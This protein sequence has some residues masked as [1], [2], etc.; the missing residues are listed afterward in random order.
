MQGDSNTATKLCSL[1]KTSPVVKHGLLL[2]MDKDTRV[3]PNTHHFCL[4]GDEFPGMCLNK[5]VQ[6]SQLS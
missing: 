4:F 1:A 2:R 5:L 3:L 6:P